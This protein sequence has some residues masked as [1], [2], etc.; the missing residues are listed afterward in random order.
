M[1]PFFPSFPTFPFRPSLPYPIHQPNDSDSCPYRHRRQRR[2][3]Q[4]HLIRAQ[5]DGAVAHDGEE[6]Q[7]RRGG[8]K[9]EVQPEKGAGISDR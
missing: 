6:H 7:Q 3:H 9:R 4:P 1:F 8:E 5:R 2:K